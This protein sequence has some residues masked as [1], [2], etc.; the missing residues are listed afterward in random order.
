MDLQIQNLS[1][2]NGKIV[3]EQAAH[4]EGRFKVGDKIRILE[5]HACLTAANFDHYYVTRG[6][7]VVDQ[8]NILRG[9]T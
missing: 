3:A 8:W 2:E 1:Q 6:N 5:H 4:L 9:R 7:E